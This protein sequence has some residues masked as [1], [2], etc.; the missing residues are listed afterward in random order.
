MMIDDAGV[1]EEWNFDLI[2]DALW[3]YQGRIDHRSQTDQRFWEI[4]DHYGGEL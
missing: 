1:G 4:V 2:T 3:P